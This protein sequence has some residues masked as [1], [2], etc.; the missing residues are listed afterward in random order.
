[1]KVLL[2]IKPKYVEEINKGSKLYEFRKVIFNDDIKTIYVYETAPT[3][4]IVGKIIIDDII[5]DSPLNLWQNLKIKVELP[6]MNF[7]NTLK[8]AIKDMQSK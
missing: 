5:E 4:K 1:M 2:S 8:I 6:N 3:K 7:L